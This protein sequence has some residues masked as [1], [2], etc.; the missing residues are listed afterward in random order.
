VIKLKKIKLIN[1]C[2]YKDFEL[3]LASGEVDCNGE[4]VSRWAMFYGPNGSFKSTFL[5]AVELLAS[6]RTLKG[7]LDNK[8]FMRKLTY[9]PNYQP[10]LVGFDKS[11]TNLFME[12]VFHTDDGDKKVVL[13]N[14]WDD[15]VGL[16]VDELPEETI[17]AASFLDADNPNSMY[18]FQISKEYGDAFLDIVGSV[19]NL[20][21]YLPKESI[22]SEYDP[23][24]GKR[25]NFYTDFVITKRGKDLVHYKSFSDGEKKIAT[26]ISALFKRSK[27]TDILMVDNVVQHIYFKRHMILIKKME[28][29]FPNHQFIATTHSPIIVSEMDDKYLHDMEKNIL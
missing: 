21:C 4:G 9:H 12:G 22:V 16:T 13:E 24:E 25:V 18:S 2:G 19:Y 27:E 29:F 28:E 1:Y 5:R 11:R 6:P 23:Q 26:L 7:R 3:D 17:S 14:N 10:S 8:L 15:R 20:K